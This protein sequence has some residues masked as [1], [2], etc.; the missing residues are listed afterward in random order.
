M[1][2]EMYL[3]DAIL[4]PEQKDIVRRAIFLYVSEMQKQFYHDE[5]IT[6]EQYDVRFQQIEEILDN[7]NLRNRHPELS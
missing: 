5:T 3:H 6:R 2:D 7:L 4:L 1:I